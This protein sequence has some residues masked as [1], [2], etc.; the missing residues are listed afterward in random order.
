MSLLGWT[1]ADA[2]NEALVYKHCQRSARL[3]DLCVAVSPCITY[4]DLIDSALEHRLA[5]EKAAK[6][7]ELS[8]QLGLPLKFGP[9]YNASIGLTHRDNMANCQFTLVGSKHSSDIYMRVSTHAPVML[10]LGLE[11]IAHLLAG[12]LGIL[13]LMSLPLSCR[14]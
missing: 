4:S 3:W 14:L 12:C 1:T 7:A 13:F 11:F 6:N 2:L 10:Q 8:E 5:L 9:W